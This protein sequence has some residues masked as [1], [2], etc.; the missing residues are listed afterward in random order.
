M[1][2][3]LT[4]NGVDY[5]ERSFVF[6]FYNIFGSFPKSGPAEDHNQFIQIRGKG[7]R[8]ESTILCSLNETKVAPLA[9]HPGVIKCP[10][11]LAG[12]PNH[13]SRNLA[14][15]PIP[16]H[17]AGKSVPFSVL[18][19]GS[20]YSFGNFR[21]YKQIEIDEVTPLIGPSEG[22]GAIYIIGKDFRD[23]FENAKLGCRIGNQLGV[24]QLVDQET[25]R[26]TVANKLPLVE[27]GESLLVSAALNSYSWAPSAFSMEPYGIYDIFPNSG[28]IGE[29]TNILVTG[30]GFENALRDQARCKFGTDA[31]YAIVE[32]QVLDN[33]H[34]ICKSPSEEISLP[35]GVDA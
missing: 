25:I 11:H 13:R 10:M 21:Y 19:D 33:E 4:F 35:D 2:V 34:L 28:P 14:D 26:C 16:D 18:I 23:D 12:W 30:K 32:A 7:F 27:E 20:K 29:S 22:R 3:D 1:R 9:V 5:T 15:Y 31:N 24:A 8:E 6:S 17:I